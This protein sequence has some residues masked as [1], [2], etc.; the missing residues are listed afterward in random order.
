MKNE[1]LD[2]DELYKD[3]AV[4]LLSDKATGDEHKLLKDWIDKEPRNK[5]Y[6]N[7]IR[8]AWR[9]SP[10]VGSNCFNAVIAWN[11]ASLSINKDF[12]RK[13]LWKRYSIAAIWLLSFF[14][15][16]SLTYMF[17]RNAVKAGT[18]LQSSINEVTAPK[19]S[20]SELLLP[21]GTHVWL[22]AGSKLRY[23]QSYNTKSREVYLEGEAYFNVK[24]NPEKPFIVKTSDLN[25]KAYGT[26]FNVKAYPEEKTITATL[27]EGKIKIIGTGPDM[28][29]FEVPLAPKQK[30]TFTK[31]PVSSKLQRKTDPVDLQEKTDSADAKP[32]PIIIEDIAETKLYTSWKDKSWYIER[33]ELDKLIVMLERRYN[34][35]F[36]CNLQELKGYKISGTIRNETLEQVLDFL[37]LT[38]PLKYIIDE[39]IVTIN[40]DTERSGNYLKIMHK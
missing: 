10:S 3:L 21:D 38:V 36:I 28:S 13:T 4:K 27:V 17:Y 30:F 15:G 11:K 25:V 6:F 22:N 24:T 40:I 39:G 19:G 1:F 20:K 34:V 16:G 5:A 9:I 37:K 8:A 29:R 31:K 23:P 14:C 18:L 33:E 35:V 2:I 32:D 12:K 26:I 7:Q